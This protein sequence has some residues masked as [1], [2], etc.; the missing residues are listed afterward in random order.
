MNMVSTQTKQ[1][2][3]EL[4]VISQLAAIRKS[5]ALIQERLTA[6]PQLEV[7]HFAAEVRRLQVSADRLNRMMDAMHLNSS[8]G[9]MQAAGSPVAA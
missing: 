7:S 6:N 2:P 1:A 5:E 8:A 4:L 9:W 3:L